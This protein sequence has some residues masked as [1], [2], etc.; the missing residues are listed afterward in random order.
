MSGRSPKA[1][2]APSSTRV[3]G[4]VIAAHGR[5]Y[6]VAPEDG[7]PMLQCFPRGKRSEVAVGD[8]VIYEPTSADQG[9]IVEIGERRN[10]LYRSDQYKSKLFAANLDQLLIVLA[11]EPHFS[12]D[13]LG[14]ALVAAEANELKPLIVLNKIDVT[15]ALEGA[16]KRLEPYRA[17]GY[18]VVEVSIKTQPEAARPA[19]LEH[20][21]GHSTLLLGQ[22]GMGKSTLVN[23]LIPDAEVA[24]REISTALNSGRHTTT[25]TRLYPL[26]GADGGAL[27]DSPGFQEFGLHHLTEGRLE[28]AFPEFRPLLPNC[29]FYNCH[30]LQ[31]PGCAILEAV[32]DGRIRRERHA[33]YAQLVHEASQ[34]V[35]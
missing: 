3:G 28:R 16:R 13:L 17:L 30:H 20:L 18:T 29:R 24:T 7:S 15:G 8:R 4:L 1:P 2:R 19:L 31:E 5:H 12:E 32:A 10:L 14:R 9:V 11:T 26:P 6:L 25:F 21:Q 23:L 33:L 27:I 35:R 34:I 22:S